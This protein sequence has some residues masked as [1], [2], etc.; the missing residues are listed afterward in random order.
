MTL[1]QKQ[2]KNCERW[3]KKANHYRMWDVTG[4]M[5]TDD[6]AANIHLLQLILALQTNQILGFIICWQYYEL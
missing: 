1:L 2:I 4:F 6:V 3:E 5:G